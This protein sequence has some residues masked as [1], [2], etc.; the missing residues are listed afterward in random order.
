MQIIYPGYYYLFETSVIVLMILDLFN[1]RSFH[2]TVSGLPVVVITSFFIMTTEKINFNPH[3][4]F[5]LLF[6]SHIK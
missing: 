2:A 1:I 5:S 4:I 3:C 6:L